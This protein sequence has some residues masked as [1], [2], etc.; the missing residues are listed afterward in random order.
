MADSKATKKASPTRRKPA[1]EKLYNYRIDARR[2]AERHLLHRGDDGLPAL[3]AHRH[4][5][6]DVLDDHDGVV[7]DPAD[8]DRERA[9]G[10]DVER[11]A[12]DLQAQQR[13]EQGQRDAQRSAR[14]C[15][16]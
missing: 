16:R 5:S 12:E 10:E 15:A 2:A 9:Q 6:F 13:R 11:V 1:T 8:R 7:D 4:V 3:L 14:G